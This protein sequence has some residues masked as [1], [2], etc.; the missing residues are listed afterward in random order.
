VISLGTSGTA[1]AAMSERAVDP[2]GTIA[3]FADAAGGFLPLAATLNCTLAVDQVASWLGLEREAVA[4]RTEVT[5]LP[6]FDGERTPN[7]PRAAGTVAGLRHDT[8]P[9]Q[10]LLAA[11]EGAA[12][13][14]IEA[15]DL[16]AGVGSG[17]N[18]E[19]PLALIGGGA[20]GQVWQ[21]V[22]ARLS[23]R[24]VQV[25][26]AEE[27]VALGAAA[28]AAAVLT[29]ERPD[30]IARGWETRRGPVVEP[31]PTPDTETLARVRATRAAA[32]ELLDPIH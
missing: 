20:R 16:L 17:L 11:Y 13:S 19:A 25:P 9:G 18:S 6:Y 2:T 4:E 23:G 29:G 30:T 8:T 21:E 24:V 26:D 27:L 12:A 15:L 28:Q 3:G 22:V 32:A 31:P 1:Y 7:L 10:I 14:L 5:V